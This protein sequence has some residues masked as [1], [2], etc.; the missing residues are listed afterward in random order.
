MLGPG[1][2]TLSINL[3][4][5]IDKN[6]AEL[7]KFTLACRSTCYLFY[8]AGLQFTKPSTSTAYLQKNVDLLEGKIKFEELKYPAP[9]I[10]NSSFKKRY[11]NANLSNFIFS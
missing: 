8:G 3:A 9:L 2:H 5:K 10:A 6:S 7:S 11:K 1:K 4:R